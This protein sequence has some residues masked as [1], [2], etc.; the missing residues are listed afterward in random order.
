[1]AE[2]IDK[3][4]LVESMK[5]KDA[6]NPLEHPSWND[7]LRTIYGIP[8][9]TEADIR[10]KAIEEF[11]EKLKYELLDTLR[12]FFERREMYERESDTGKMYSHGIGTLRGVNYMI[13]EIA[14]QLK[15]E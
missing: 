1:M 14:E 3:G 13:D 6:E 9:V 2:L 15:G 7:A 12:I 10:A 5:R 11:A 4:A 8:T